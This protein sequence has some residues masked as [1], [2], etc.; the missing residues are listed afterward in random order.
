M[1][2]KRPRTARRELERDLKK[3]VR[4]KERL[5]KLEPGGSEERPMEVSSAAVIEVR[6]TGVGIADA[7]INRVIVAFERAGNAVPGKHEGVG[8]GL[9]IVSNLAKLH[10]G[11]L[12]LRSQPGKGT[13]AQLHLPAARV[14]AIPSGQA[15]AA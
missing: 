3:L 8:L 11:E 12:R 7:D 14:S 4:D 15:T 5:F 13:S 2:G 10:G 1:S 6:D 9:A